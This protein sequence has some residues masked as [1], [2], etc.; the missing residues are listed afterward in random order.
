M[1]IAMIAAANMTN[2]P[3]IL[4]LGF[5]RLIMLRVSRIIKMTKHIKK[6]KLTNGSSGPT[7]MVIFWYVVIFSQVR[8]I[9]NE[10]NPVAFGMA[11][12]V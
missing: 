5:A 12:K 2:N 9:E 6:S 1:G 10:K 8:L 3:T 11:L 4:S 7:R